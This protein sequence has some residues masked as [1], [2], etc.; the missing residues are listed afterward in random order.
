MC[1]GGGMWLG[2]GGRSVNVTRR[3][4]FVVV[5]FAVVLSVVVDMQ[6]TV[7]ENMGTLITTYVN[8]RAR[9]REPCTHSQTE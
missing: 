9:V 8:T 2:G 4:L 3:V 5:G 7:T 6:F 1:G